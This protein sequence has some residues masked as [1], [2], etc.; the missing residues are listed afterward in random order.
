MQH[1]LT[2]R[3]AAVERRE[4]RD[5][6]LVPSAAHNQAVA[7]AGVHEGGDKN[8][9]ELFLELRQY[10]YLLITSAAAVYLPVHIL[11]DGVQPLRRAA[12]IRRRARVPTELG[13]LLFLL[14]VFFPD[15]DSVHI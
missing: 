14:R 1:T 6:L 8:L 7:L 10:P 11:S 12:A 13:H 3:S 4:D 15:H 2:P 9:R 5:P